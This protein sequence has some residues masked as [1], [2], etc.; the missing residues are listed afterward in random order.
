MYTDNKEII[1]YLKAKTA[2]RYSD[3]IIY[4]YDAFIVRKISLELL[5]EYN[6]KY[7]NLED[8]LQQV[9]PVEQIWNIRQN[10]VTQPIDKKQNTSYTST[11]AVVQAPTSVPVPPRMP[12]PK[13]LSPDE[14]LDGW[15][16]KD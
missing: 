12:I 11:P 15:M 14:M 3:N 2:L 7:E 8:F 4:A 5:R 16:I 9:D 6:G 1:K 13:R 10:S